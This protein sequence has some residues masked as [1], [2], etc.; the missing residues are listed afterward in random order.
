M[1]WIGVSLLVATLGITCL[2]QESQPTAAAEPSPELR[3][4]P[5]AKIEFA[6]KLW[7]KTNDFQTVARLDAVESDDVCYTMRSYLFER[8]STD[9]PEMVGETTCTPASK[10]SFKSV[11]P[12]PARLIPAY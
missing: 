2:A 11:T 9:S 8:S 1:R 10:S 6:P 4:A 7:E 12:K 5:D 3:I